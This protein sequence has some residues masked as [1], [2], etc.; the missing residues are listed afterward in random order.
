MVLS[1]AWTFSVFLDP[2]DSWIDG[3]PDPVL[4]AHEMVRGE[5]QSD[6]LHKDEVNAERSCNVIGN[7]HSVSHCL[8]E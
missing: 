6:S 1:Y 4:Q 7:D 5:K 8:L 3:Y 2:G